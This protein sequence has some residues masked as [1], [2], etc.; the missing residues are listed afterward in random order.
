MTTKDLILFSKIQKIP[1][2]SFERGLE[3]L[4]INY[5]HIGKQVEYFGVFGVNFHLDK[6]CC[7]DFRLIFNQKQNITECQGPLKVG[8]EQIF[9]ILYE[10]VKKI[11]NQLR[12][13]VFFKKSSK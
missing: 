10:K 12:F 6:K 4:S 8:I 11:D 3:S 5:C 13:G 2:L 1:H 9:H 7:F